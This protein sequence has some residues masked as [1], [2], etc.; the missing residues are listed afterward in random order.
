MHQS[1]YKNKSILILAS[2]AALLAGPPRSPGAWAQQVSSTEILS[3]AA[4]NGEETG[5]S[6]GR[7]A[8]YEELRIQAVGVGNNVTGEY[9]RL[10]RFFPDRTASIAEKVFEEKSNLPN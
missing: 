7:L 6:F 4:S 8:R 9:Y 10:S 3:R 1:P 2:V 5:L